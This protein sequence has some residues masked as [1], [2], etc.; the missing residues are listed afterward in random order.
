V[1]RRTAGIEQAVSA[2]VV[3]DDGAVAQRRQCAG[4]VAELIEVALGQRGRIGQR[5]QDAFAGLEF[6]GDQ[7][8]ESAHGFLDAAFLGPPFLEIDVA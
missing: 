3:E 4:V 7:Q 6:V 2:R 8:G 1:A 5:V